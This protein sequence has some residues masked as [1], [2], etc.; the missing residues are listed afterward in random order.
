[1]VQRKRGFCCGEEVG[2]VCGC[3]RRDERDET[4]EHTYDAGR[5]KG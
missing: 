3:G 2:G 1:M 4:D 5:V